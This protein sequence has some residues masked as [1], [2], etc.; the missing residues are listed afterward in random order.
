MGRLVGDEE[1]GGGGDGFFVGWL[2]F[3][4]CVCVCVE[5]LWKRGYGMREEAGREHT[6]AGVEFHGLLY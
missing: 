2:V 5:C 3:S 1:E 4:V 6:G